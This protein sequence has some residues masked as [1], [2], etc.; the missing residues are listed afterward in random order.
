MKVGVNWEVTET[1]LDLE[2]VLTYVSGSYDLCAFAQKIYSKNLLR[3]FTQRTCSRRDV[4]IFLQGIDIDGDGSHELVVG[5]PRWRD[6][7][8][9]HLGGG[10]LS[11]TKIPV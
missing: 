10:I 1:I 6:N 8:D 5:A 4:I 2:R 7:D 9:L 11:L 3:K